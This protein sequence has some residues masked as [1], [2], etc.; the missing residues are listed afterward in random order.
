MPNEF[1][2]PGHND[3]CVSDIYIQLDLIR[4]AKHK[5]LTQIS[6]TIEELEEKHRKFDVL[7]KQERYWILELA[8][9][10]K[11]LGMGLN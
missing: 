3:I 11:L 2:I 1:N 4:Q 9:Q 6:S 10:K 7:E 8:R 5:V